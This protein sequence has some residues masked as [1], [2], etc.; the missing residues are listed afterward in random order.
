M[1]K[2][3]KSLSKPHIS[4][5]TFSTKRGRGRPGVRA[6]E[7]YNRACGY[8]IIFSQIWNDR[9]GPQGEVLQGL[10]N[11][12][13]RAQTEAEVIKALELWPSYQSEFSPLAGL[14]LKV[15]RDKD[16]PK[17][18]VPQMNF[19]ADSLAARGVRSARRSRDICEEERAKEKRAHRI[20]R[21]EW[22]IECSCGYKGRSRDHA[23]PKCGAQIE[24][25]NGSGLCDAP[26][27]DI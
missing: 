27:C 18:R 13:L 2:T 15:L 6:S 25:A 21:Y 11:D 8:R 24:Y 16:F 22:Y 3:K 5:D 19:L 1:P 10:G 4:L 12:L 23:C 7:V 20:L 26:S 14:I 9:P 17:R